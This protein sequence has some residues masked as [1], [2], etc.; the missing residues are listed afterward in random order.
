MYE[1]QTCKNIANFGYVRKIFLSIVVINVT[2][3]N[4]KSIHAT[5]NLH[6]K[7]VLK[8]KNLFFK[9]K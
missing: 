6:I 5:H 9:N 2:S 4:A 8:N 3:M 1:I 7:N